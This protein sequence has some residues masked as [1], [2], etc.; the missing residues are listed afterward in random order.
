MRL[1]IFVMVILTVIIN[2]LT[3]IFMCRNAVWRRDYDLA[4]AILLG[5]YAIILAYLPNSYQFW[6]YLAIGW[7]ILLFVFIFKLYF[8]DIIKNGSPWEI[9]WMVLGILV[10]VLA[11]IIIPHI[12][13]PEWMY[14]IPAI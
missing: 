10:I 14:E 4:L 7:G 5:L 2:F 6:N 9:L 13:L 12:Q 11:V 1:V 8:E 3:G